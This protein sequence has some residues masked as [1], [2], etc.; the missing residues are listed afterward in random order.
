MQ[1]FADSKYL[2][3]ICIYMMEVT[4]LALRGSYAVCEGKIRHPILFCGS[5]YGSVSVTSVQ[6]RMDL[7]T[8]HVTV[9][10]MISFR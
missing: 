1:I 2:H 5:L 9:L 7:V 6:R 10:V 3:C 8:F 4:L